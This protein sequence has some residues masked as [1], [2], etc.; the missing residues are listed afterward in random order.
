MRKYSPIKKGVSLL[1]VA[2]ILTSS[3]FVYAVAAQTSISRSQT[4]SSFG[5]I[6]SNTVSTSPT[7]PPT[8]TPTPSPSPTATPTPGNSNLPLSAIGDDY[9]MWW[10]SER[11]PLSLGQP[12]SLVHTIPL[13][14]RKTRILIR[15]RH[16]KQ[17]RLHLRIL[18]NERRTNKTKLSRRKSSNMQLRRLRL[19][20]LRQPSLDQR[21]ETSNH[22]LQRRH[23]NSSLRNRKRTLPELSRHPMRIRCPP[24]TQPAL[25]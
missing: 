22:R 20:L 11:R 18:K 14:R 6:V 19:P 7:P 9:L 4:I 25:H 10:N 8:S 2:V 5:S 13:H 16:R 23:T 12:T 21:L 1:L 17:Q 3:L 15:R 24:S